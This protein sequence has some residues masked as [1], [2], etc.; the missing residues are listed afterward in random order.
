M[1]KEF[2]GDSLI[3][4]ETK[5]ENKKD[6]EKLIDMIDTNK[7]KE[8]TLRELK[9]FLVTKRIYKI[10]E[11]KFLWIHD[12]VNVKKDQDTTGYYYDYDE[13]TKKGT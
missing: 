5:K 10:D 6:L 7:N 13:E 1:I 11:E 9:K 12:E 8:M 3:D 2:L 4:K